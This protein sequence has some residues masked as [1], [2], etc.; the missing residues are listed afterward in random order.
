MEV[1]FQRNEFGGTQTFKHSHGKSVINLKPLCEMVCLLN[2]NV[3]INYDS[4]IPFCY[5]S[6]IN[7]C[8]SAPKD[9]QSVFLAALFVIATIWKQPKWSSVED[10]YVNFD[11]FIHRNNTQQW[12]RTNLHYMQQCG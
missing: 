11:V 8:I 7:M 1:R 9:L 4:T 2:V 10:G 3:H 12:Q 5:T 6:F